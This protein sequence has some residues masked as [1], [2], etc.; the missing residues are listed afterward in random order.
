MIDPTILVVIGVAAYALW[1]GTGGTSA[2]E[3]L[4]L[5]P[6]G[7]LMSNIIDDPDRGEF[8]RASIRTLSEVFAHVHL[9]A[10]GPVWQQGGPGTYVVVASARPIDRRRSSAPRAK[11]SWASAPG[12]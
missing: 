9:V 10:L 8:L 2:A 1:Q 12:Q 7:I 11:R 4:A 3:A 6:D 5:K